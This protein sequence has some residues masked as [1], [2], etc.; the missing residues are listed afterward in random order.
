M[1]LPKIWA[2]PQ[3][4]SLPRNSPKMIRNSAAENVISPATSV[5]RASGSRDSWTL[6]TASTSAKTPTGKQDRV[7]PG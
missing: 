6:R 2:L 7:A 3:P 5:L 1:R 4:A